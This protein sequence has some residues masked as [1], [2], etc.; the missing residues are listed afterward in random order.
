MS[1]D[2]GE[3][4]MQSWLRHVKN[5]DLVQTN[6]KAAMHIVYNIKNAETLLGELK[7]A[8][9][10][11]T[12]KYSAQTIIRQTE[13]DVLGCIVAKKRYIA[14]DIAFHEDGLHYKDIDVVPSKMLRTILCLYG[15]LGAKEA[16]VVFATPYIKDVKERA[17]YETFVADLNSF[18]KSHP[19]LSKYQAKL[20]TG[21]DFEANILN[22]VLHLVGKIKDTSEVFVRACQLIKC[23]RGAGS[24]TLAA[25][26][27]GLY[28]HTGCGQID[29]SELSTQ[30]I[31]EQYI[32]PELSK[33][34]RRDLRPYF[35]LKRS[36]EMFHAGYAF[37]S[38]T[39]V[40]AGT[41]ARYYAE[42]YYLEKSDQTVYI[43]NNCDPAK[44]VDWINHSAI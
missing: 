44:L 5:C 4:L 40:F 8:F 36:N 30:Q 13:I 38:F 3:S 35:D 41:H 22:S 37:L 12:T 16:T 7:M 26:G 29:V 2:I 1:V 25:T 39:R 9:P 31:I 23:T 27:G 15:F 28:I 24:G 34:C 11:F 10:F 43:T 42:A 19:D 20:Y 14:G 6:W 32:L 18:L 33:K 21:L 17:Y